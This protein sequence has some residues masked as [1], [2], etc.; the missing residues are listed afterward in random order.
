MKV[1]VDSLITKFNG[2]DIKARYAIFATALLVVFAVDYALIMNFQLQ[3]I[4]R[5]NEEIKTLSGDT[6][7]VQ[8]DKQRIDQMRKGLESSRTQ[9]QAMNVKIRSMQEVPLILD[10]ISRLANEVGIKIDQLIPRKED[11]EKLISSPEG[12]FYALPI[13]ISARGGYHPWGRFLSRL[14]A[15]NLYFSLSE[16]RIDADEKDKNNHLITA[17][18]KVILGDKPIGEIAQP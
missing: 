7:R 18:L 16:L 8:A 10:D 4:G 12:D 15:A 2:L 13:V 6:A 11:Q 3:F 1:T 5:S 17:T 9:L 14:E